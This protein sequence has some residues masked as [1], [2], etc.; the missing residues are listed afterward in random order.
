MIVNKTVFGYALPSGSTVEYR[1][2]NAKYGSYELDALDVATL[3]RLGT[4]TNF[5]SSV[6]ALG[7]CSTDGN[8]YLINGWPGY[9]SNELHYIG[10]DGSTRYYLLRSFKNTGVTQPSYRS[11]TVNF[12]CTEW[13]Q[14]TG[15]YSPNINH[16]TWEWYTGNVRTYLEDIYNQEGVEYRVRYQIRYLKA[17]NTYA[18]ATVYVTR[19]TTNNSWVQWDAVADVSTSSTV[20]S[21][22]VAYWYSN[23][24][25]QR[26]VNGTWTDVGVFNLENY[27]NYTGVTSGT[28]SNFSFSIGSTNTHY[29]AT[30]GSNGSSVHLCAYDT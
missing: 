6:T 19:S 3:V 20:P 13:G 10:P 24:V 17:P 16:L 5:P 12:R 30:M 15:Q 26:K 28:I 25:L 11:I 8:K 14:Y 29:G 2:I 4:D 23:P 1:G 21:S 18:T 22:S 27:S 9:F 7:V